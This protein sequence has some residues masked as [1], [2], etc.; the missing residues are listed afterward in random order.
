MY[1]DLYW[2]FWLWTWAPWPRTV[3]W[4]DYLCGLVHHNFSFFCLW[5]CTVLFI[6]SHQAWQLIPLTAAAAA[7]QIQRL[8]SC[9]RQRPGAAVDFVLWWLCG[10]FRASEFEARY[11]LFA[12]AEIMPQFRA[13]VKKNNR[14]IVWNI[15]ILC[16]MMTGVQDVHRRSCRDSL[17]AA[18]AS[19]QLK[20]SVSCK[21]CIKSV[22]NR[23]NWICLVSDC[24]LLEQLAVYRSFSFI[25]VP[26]PL[27]LLQV[28]SGSWQ[29]CCKII[30]LLLISVKSSL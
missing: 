20:L 24:S 11:Y 18:L 13:C 21:N 25:T 1:W 7:S 19:E 6:I 29:A 16:V 2:W 14:N 15:V 17:G 12:Q 3:W 23:I 26:L 22:L 9:A 4:S 30:N 5:S 8:S 28:S 27:N 10:R